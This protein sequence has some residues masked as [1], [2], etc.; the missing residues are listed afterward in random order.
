MGALHS[1]QPYAQTLRALVL[2]F[3]IFK[4]A[5]MPPLLLTSQKY[6]KEPK[7]P[8]CFLEHSKDIVFN[9]KMRVSEGFEQRRQ[10]ISLRL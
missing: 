3:P 7:E 9:P 10:A 5:A 4:M 1:I 6:G 2:S 8:D